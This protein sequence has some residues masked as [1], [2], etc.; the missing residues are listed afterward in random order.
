MT[1]PNAKIDLKP[2]QIPLLRVEKHITALGV[3]AALMPAVAKA[4]EEK[5]QENIVTPA[6]VASLQADLLDVATRL[7]DIHLAFET[8]ANEIGADLFTTA[9]NHYASGGDDKAPPIAQVIKSLM[10]IS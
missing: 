9:V 6:E 10:G 4:A 2:Q 7:G 3:Y 8:K 1:K 5:L